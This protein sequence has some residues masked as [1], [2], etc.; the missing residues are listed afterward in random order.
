LS[1]DLLAKKETKHES[2]QIGVTEELYSCV[3]VSISG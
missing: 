2:T 1:N 3:F